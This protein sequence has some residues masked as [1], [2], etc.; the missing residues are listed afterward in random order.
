MGDPTR[1]HAIAEHPHPVT[2]TALYTTG[3]GVAVGMGFAAPMVTDDGALTG[4]GPAG[5]S[6]VTVAESVTEPLSRSAW[7]IV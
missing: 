4:C 6:A 5:G 2:G 7:V 1:F 3:L